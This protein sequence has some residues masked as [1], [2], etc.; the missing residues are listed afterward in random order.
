LGWVELTGEEEKSSVQENVEESRSK[1]GLEPYE[2]PP[3]KYYRL[4]QRVIEAP[5]YQWS[6]QLITC[7][8]EIAG[9]PAM[10]YFRGKRKGRL[11]V[12]KRP[13]RRHSQS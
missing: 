3:R 7:H 10:E 2:T 1:A 4:T 5:D 8:P 13:T 11:Y 9:I 12:R 6:N